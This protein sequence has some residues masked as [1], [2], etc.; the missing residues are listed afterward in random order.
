VKRIHLAAGLAERGGRVLLA[1]SR[2]PNHAEPLWNLPGGRQAHGELLPAT[3]IREIREET[4]LQARVVE[5]AYV[6]ESY[7]GDD[8]FLCTVFRVSVEGTV[9]LPAA[10]DHVVAVEWVSIAELASRIVVP[11]VREPLVAHLRQ[12]LPQRYA[13]YEEAG[14]TIAWPDD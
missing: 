8:H 6:S 14:V 1:A 12:M 9:R 11:V 7:D 10:G 5:L 13:G 2:Y 4:G 3:A